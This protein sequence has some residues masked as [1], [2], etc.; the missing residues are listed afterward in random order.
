M[1]TPS[2]ALAKELLPTSVGPLT[3]AR[4]EGLEPH[5]QTRRSGQ[6]ARDRLSMVVGW[7]GIPELSTCVRWAV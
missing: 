5:F 3:W 4:S 7:A 1:P 6:V 2:G